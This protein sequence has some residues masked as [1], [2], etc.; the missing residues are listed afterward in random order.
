[1]T[2]PTADADWVEYLGADAWEEL[3]VCPT[4]DHVIEPDEEDEDLHLQ[5]CLR[6]GFTLI[7]VRLSRDEDDNAE[8]SI[9]WQ[10]GEGP[11]L[12]VA[13][14][15]QALTTAQKFWAKRDAE[16]ERIDEAMNEIR[17]ERRAQADA[18]SN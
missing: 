8:L 18:E 2:D 13:D 5:P 1:V 14:A 17:L 12:F 6:C 3:V 7:R 15:T 9:R 4:C 16:D 10:D 11:Q